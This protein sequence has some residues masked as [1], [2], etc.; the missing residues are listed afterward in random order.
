M[1]PVKQRGPTAARMDARSRILC[2]LRVLAEVQQNQ[3]IGVT[4]GGAFVVD[5]SW[6]SRRWRGDNRDRFCAA[7]AA[8]SESLRTEVEAAR[9]L[10]GDI[11]TVQNASTHTSAFLRGLEQWLVD[12]SEAR[13]RAADALLRMSSSTYGTDV[14]TSQRVA[15]LAV[16]LRG[17]VPI[18]NGEGG[19]CSGE[20]S[21]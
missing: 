7:L 17:F 8:E 10:Y 12:V 9:A 14:R 4:D 6:V 19:G 2:N 16:S 5:T 3:R 11:A 13:L 21:D 18:T 15:Q 1:P 20:R